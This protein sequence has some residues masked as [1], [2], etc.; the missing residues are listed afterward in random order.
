LKTEGFLRAVSVIRL[1]PRYLAAGAFLL[2]AS[3]CVSCSGGK[4]PASVGPVT[5]VC[6]LNAHPCESS[7]NLEAWTRESLEENFEETIAEGR[8]VYRV[9]DYDKAENKR[10]MDDYKLP[11]QSVVL[12]DGADPERWKRLDILWQK[13]GDEVDFK[14]TVRDE[15][16]K[17]L[18]GG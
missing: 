6:F 12:Q 18:A 3:V 13:M 11:F 16:S 2:L 7:R 4:K 15:T 10:F 5:C 9:L 8:L 14:K 17:F 1:P